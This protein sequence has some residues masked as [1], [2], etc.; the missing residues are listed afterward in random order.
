MDAILESLYEAYKPEYASAEEIA[1]LTREEA[2]LERMEA[3]LGTEDF[4]EFWD[5]VSEVGM[6]RAEE[7]FTLGF[8]LGAQLSKT[9]LGLPASESI[10]TI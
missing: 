5:I 3:E 4:G 9:I 1:L 2:F 6:L 7:G 10:H 8:R